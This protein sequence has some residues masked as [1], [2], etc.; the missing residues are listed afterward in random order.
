MALQEEMEVQGNYLFMY[1]SKWPLLILPVG[2]VIYVYQEYMKLG[3]AEWALEE[4]YPYISMLVAL[5]GLAVR[6]YTVGH[7]PVNTSGRNSSSDQLA[8]QL[9]TTGIYSM[10]RHPLYLGNFFIWL[11]MAM[12]TENVWFVLTF[13]LLFWIYYERIMFAE[14]QFLKRKFNDEFVAWAAKT[15]AFIPAIR[16]YRPP[17]LSFSIKKVM[18]KEKNGLF[19][20]FLL[21]FIFQYSEDI[22][23]TRSLA[24]TLDFWAY[25]VIV[26]GLF[27]LVFKILKKHTTLL[28][29]P[30]R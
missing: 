7:T 11:G 30:D 24:I 18:K 25:A 20:I 2:L 3:M 19:A 12:L 28:Y 27:Y 29:E 1:R 14:E 10:V 22:V 15:P 4:L 16:N 26:T 6:V 21:I 17:E 13:V 8:D 23:Q 9:N 5:I